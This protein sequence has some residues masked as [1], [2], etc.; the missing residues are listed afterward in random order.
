MQNTDN[1][2]RMGNIFVNFAR[3]EHMKCFSLLDE[4]P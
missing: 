3:R 4:E 2:E 1:E